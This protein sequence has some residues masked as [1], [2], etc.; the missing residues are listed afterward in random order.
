MK[1]FRCDGT[2]FC[3]ECY[4]KILQETEYP[5]L[6]KTNT[7]LIDVDSG[8]RCEDCKELCSNL[9]SLNA[10]KKIVKIWDKNTNP[11]GEKD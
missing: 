5:E 11:I 7:K 4:L 2:I 3:A 1:A 10:M 9:V 6:V 8:Y